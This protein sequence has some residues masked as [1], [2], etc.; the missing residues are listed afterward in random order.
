MYMTQ[1]RTAI[2]P[3]YSSTFE[4]TI[5]WENKKNKFS[6]DFYLTS[7]INIILY[8]VLAME[9]STFIDLELFIMLLQQVVKKNKSMLSNKR[10][11]LF[12]LVI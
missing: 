9:L 7:Q 12:Q 3:L 1:K 5:Q 10:S 11:R 6:Q 2:A 4:F 8:W